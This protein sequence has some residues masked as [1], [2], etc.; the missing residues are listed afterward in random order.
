MV[1]KMHSSVLWYGKDCRTGARGR[2]IK[3][4]DIMED[5]TKDA[6]ALQEAARLASKR[7][8]ESL[9]ELIAPEA[10]LTIREVEILEKPEQVDAQQL[11]KRCIEYY[12]QDKV[13]VSSLIKIYSGEEKTDGGVVLMF[14]DQSDVD[15]LGSLIL[16]K[17]RDDEDRMRYGMQE[18][19]ITEALNIIG[20]AYIEVVGEFYNTTIMSMVPQIVDAMTFDDFIGQII[21]GSTKKAYIIF[22]THLL[23]TDHSIEIPFLLAVS[24]W[25]KE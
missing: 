22:N 2:A 1:L 7:A 9:Q 19:A 16:R 11:A 15:S 12:Q 25:E 17:L 21:S 13:I 3:K 4:H 23:V 5:R 24:L 8:S 18:S 14:L 20:N 10:T 6:S